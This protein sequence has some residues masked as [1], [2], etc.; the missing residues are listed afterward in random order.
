[1]SS[2]KIPTSSLHMTREDAT[3]GPDSSSTKKRRMLTRLT[4]DDLAA[5]GALSGARVLMR[6][7]FNVPM[8]KG[9][10]PCEISNPQRVEEAIPT[11]RK[12]LDSGAKCCVLM[13]HL[14]RPAG[15]ITPSLSL[16]PVAALLETLLGP[17]RSV[18]FLDDCVGDAVEKAVAAA[19]EGSVILLENLRFHAEE[20]GKG[21]RADGSK[22]VP[23]KADVDAFRRK[24]FSLG[25]VYIND[26]FGTAHRAHSSMVGSPH[27]HRAAGLLLKKELDYFGAALEAPRRPFLCI[28]GGAKVTDKIQLI[29]NLLDKADAM[30]IGG[31]MAFTF[32]KVIHNMN[33][34]GSLFDEEGAKIVT[35]IVAKA[36]AKNVALHLPTDFVTADAFSANAAVGH[37]TVAGSVGIPDGWMGLD[38]GPETSSNFA[39]VISQS[40]TIVWNGPMG[41][42]EFD[43][44]ANG[45]K[46]VMDAVVA[47]T[48]KNET[49]AVPEAA[50][51]AATPAAAMKTAGA[52]TI[53][54]GGDT[55][56]CAKKFGTE[57]LVSHVSTGGGASLEFL[58]GKELPG[59]LALSSA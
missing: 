7:D 44:F 46:A 34:G 31:G 40:R 11:I 26:A 38:I 35:R 16:R 39:Q 1:M 49:A 10:T 53:I 14:G 56:T 45:T 3:G 51:L 43:A 30:I 20:E 28:L 19:A 25:D 32:L 22:F 58:E 23:A 48:G 57:L 36:K 15:N 9:T 42:F 52:T 27:K 6:V 33:I 5:R 24:L 18:T 50:A 59:V 21:K 37:A 12:V 47:V 4:V 8:V 54:G 13:S 29:D 2:S 55:A 17:E 41:V